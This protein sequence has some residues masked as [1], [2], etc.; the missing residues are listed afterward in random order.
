MCVCVCVCLGGGGSVWCMQTEIST[1]LFTTTH[2]LEPPHT[3]LQCPTLTPPA[4][5]L[6]EAAGIPQ[7]TA[8]L[9]AEEQAEN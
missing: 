4:V 5:H 9:L 2:G 7:N 6:S 1:R 3:H 8:W